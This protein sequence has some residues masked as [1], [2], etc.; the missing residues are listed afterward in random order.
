MPEVKSVVVKAKN[1]RSVAYF[2][3]RR[4]YKIKLS[5]KLSKMLKSLEYQKKKHHAAL[6]KINKQKAYLS[7]VTKKLSTLDL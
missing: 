3:G 4:N 1:K 6:K 7:D 5:T 2:P